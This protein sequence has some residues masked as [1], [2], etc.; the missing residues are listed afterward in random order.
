MI[1]LRITIEATQLKAKYIIIMPTLE[2]LKFQ[3]INTWKKNN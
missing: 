3:G 1:D 2:K